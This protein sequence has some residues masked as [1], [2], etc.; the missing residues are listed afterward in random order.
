[1]SYV[2][3]CGS[4]GECRGGFGFGFGNGALSSFPKMLSLTEEEEPTLMVLVACH[5]VW[6]LVSTLILARHKEEEARI[7][8]TDGMRLV[9]GIWPESLLFLKFSISYLYVVRLCASRIF[10]SLFWNEASFWHNITTG[11]TYCASR[12]F[13]H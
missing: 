3:C 11:R 1:M 5:G 9:S 6:L 2:L 7:L 12:K 13:V 10:V 8:H 4:P